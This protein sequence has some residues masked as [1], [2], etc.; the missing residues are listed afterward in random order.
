ML[1]QHDNTLVM[2]LGQTNVGTVV[3]RSFI[4]MS[5]IE[6]RYSVTRRIPFGRDTQPGFNVFLGMGLSI[7]EALLV[8]F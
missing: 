2:P 5:R 8:M 4:E 3:R 7:Y 1:Y 6:A